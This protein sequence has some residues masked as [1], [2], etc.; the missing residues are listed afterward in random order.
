MIRK[1]KLSV[2]NQT[3]KGTLVLPKLI[4]PNLSA[5]LLIHGWTSSEKGYIPRAKAISK[6][7]YVCLTFNLRGHGNSDGELGKLS[8]KDHLKDAISA[9]DFLVAQK[10]VNKNKIGVIG[11]SYGGY[12]ASLLASKRKIKWLVLRA[13]AL[14]PDESFEAASKKIDINHNINYR[15]QKID[16]NHNLAL[17]SLSKYTSDL[18]LI[19]S[20]KDEVI[21]KQTI[22]NYLNAINPQANFEHKIIKGATHD[23]GKRTRNAKWLNEFIRILEDWFSQKLERL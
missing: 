14:Y 7:G 20:E 5:V 3:I 19:E 13:P 11:S 23:L 17:S 22:L 4:K 1:I 12:M 16:K 18:L 10:G 21:S 15:K 9:Y 2:E 6:L 8:R